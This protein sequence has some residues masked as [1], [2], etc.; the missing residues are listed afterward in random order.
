MST[1]YQAT[2]GNKD[3][4]FTLKVH[5][6]DGMC[7]L[8][9]NWK[10][11]KPPKDFVGFAI[12]YREPGGERFFALKNRLA[13]PGAD[14]DVNPNRLSTRLSPIQ[15][16]RWVHFPRNAEMDGEFTYRVT[17]VFMNARGELSYGDMQDASIELRRETY[18]GLLNVTYT[19]GF[20][21]SQAFVDKYVTPVGASAISKLLPPKADEGLDF[22][23]THPRADE[24]LA[25]MGFE[26]RSAIIEL[27]DEAIKDTSAKIKVVAYDL[28]EAEIVS[29]LIKLKARLTIIIDDSGSHGK[30]HSGESQAADRLAKAG[31]KV[32]RQHMGSLQ[33]NK[34][35]VVNG[36]KVKGAV[37]GSTNFTW[38]GLFVQNNHAVVLRTA[39]AVAVFEKAFDDYWN[40]D[41]VAGFGATP[42]ALWNDLKVAGVAAKAAFS[43]HIASNA[44]LKDIGQDISSTSSSLFFSLAFLYQTKGP[45][46]EAITKLQKD[47]QIFSYGISD[48]A[49]KGLELKKPDGKVVVVSPQELSKNLPAPFKKEPTGGGGTRLHHKFLVVD[50][51]QPNARVY[52]G[53]YNFSVPADTSNG[54]NLLCIADRRI[55][56]SFVVEAVRIFDHYHFRVAQAEAKKAREKLQ[57]RPAPSRSSEKP[58]WDEHYRNARKIRDRELF[59]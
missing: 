46:R 24:A 29:R 22:R 20:V 25:W 18:P 6:G 49:V 38:R 27:L 34:T 19:R 28:S 15:K 2:G 45:I 9:M 17:P 53:S 54:E 33:H 14:G 48:H 39:H 43:P 47:D 57:L 37:C 3:A 41:S 10:K 55:A 50:F 44:L 16:F 56:T 36:K 26:A 21:S 11:G 23:P 13:F 59:A 1:T 30:A 52:F 5:R 40:N 35:I 32:K 8:A 4:L 31:A 12:E 58:W 51:D 7:L 42:S